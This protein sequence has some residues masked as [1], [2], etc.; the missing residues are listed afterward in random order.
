MDHGRSLA[1]ILRPTAPKQ[2]SSTCLKGGGVGRRMRRKTALL[3]RIISGARVD[4]I[5]AGAQARQRGPFY[6]S[7]KRQRALTGKR[8]PK[9]VSYRSY[10]N[11]VTVIPEGD[12]YEMLGWIAPRLNKFS[13]SHSYFSWLTPPK[14]LQTSTPISQRRPARFSRKRSVRKGVAYGYIPGI[15]LIKAILAG[16]IDKMENLGIYEVI[17]EDLALCEFV[18]TSK[19]DVQQIVRQGIDLF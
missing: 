16:D 8:S 9:T 4:S 18:C 6:A 17:E 11:T 10:A 5:T 1:H 2:A 3:P 14:E 12:Y 19:T 13:M 15:Y 7:Y